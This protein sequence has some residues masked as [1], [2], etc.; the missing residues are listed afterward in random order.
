LPFLLNFYVLNDWDRRKIP[1]CLSLSQ[2]IEPNQ[3]VP[4]IIYINDGCKGYEDFLLS[5]RHFMPV[6]RP[7]A[8]F[9]PNVRGNIGFGAEHFNAAKDY[10]GILVKEDVVSIARYVASL[11]FVDPSNIFIWGEGSGSR[12]AI[13]ALFS[14]PNLFKAGLSGCGPDDWEWF[15]RQY[16]L[17]PQK[18]APATDQEDN[19]VMPRSYTIR[20]LTNPLLIYHETKDEYVKMDVLRALA[21]VPGIDKLLP[22]C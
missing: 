5:E 18:C 11:D 17:E 8:L 7:C 14:H 12:A 3:K 21:E 9:L 20:D 16:I 4:A 1:T 10:M 19:Q 13:S 15:L 6:H 2:G 22:T